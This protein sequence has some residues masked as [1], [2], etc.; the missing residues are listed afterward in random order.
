MI[1]KTVSSII[2]ML[3]NCVSHPQGSPCGGLFKGLRPLY[4]ISKFI[5][6][7]SLLI[8]AIL[9]TSC[10]GGGGGGNNGNGGDSDNSAVISAF[11]FTSAKNSSVL[12][13][14]ATGFISGTNISVTVPYNTTVTGLVA[15]FT[16]TGTSVKIGSTE[17]TSGTT[18]NDFSS[19]KTYTVTGAEG[20]TQ[21]YTV[22]V[23]VAT[24]SAKEI[25]AFSFP[26]VTWD[27]NLYNLNHQNGNDLGTAIS[28][29]SITA[30]LPYGST[31]MVA[32]FA[33]SGASVTV[34]GVPQVSG[35]TS[36]DFKN[37]VTYRVTAADNSW[38]DYTV[39]V[40]FVPAVNSVWNT[41]D[42]GVLS[43]YW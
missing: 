13:A 27:N 33:T 7:T 6:A 28:G 41:L 39:T 38:Q 18:P 3:Q 37:P 30:K 19:P 2:D 20:S 4:P 23:T 32:T 36:N 16:T 35:V 9:F 11:G 5:F 43:T 29:M 14:D 40:L 12:S 21:D 17:Q 26:A 31:S 42:G 10:G 34:G 8:T 1:K 22:T 24:A 15:T 25:T